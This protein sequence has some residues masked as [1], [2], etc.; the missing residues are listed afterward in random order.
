MKKTKAAILAA[1]LCASMTGCSNNNVNVTAETT[2]DTTDSETAS[3]TETTTAE[4]TTESETTTAEETATVTETTVE[5]AE[6]TEDGKLI[7]PSG[8][9]LDK[10][11]IVSDF[12][13][14]SLSEI[15]KPVLIAELSDGSNIYGVC[16]DGL[17][18][19]N[20]EKLFVQYTIIEHDGIADEFERNCFGRFGSGSPVECELINID[21]DD[22]MEIFTRTY[23]AGG[24]MCCIYD[25]AVF[26]MNENGHYE[27]IT[28]DIPYVDYDPM[29]CGFGPKEKAFADEML[30]KINA[31]WADDNGSVRFFTD[32]SECTAVLDK[33]LFGDYTNEDIKE[34][35]NYISS[36]KEFSF[37]GDT[38]YLKITLMVNNPDCTCTAKGELIYS[39]GSF[40]LGNVLLDNEW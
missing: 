22:D 8:W 16:V 6:T 9:V 19:E 21:D 24:T 40:T 23:I 26:D 34:N 38:L 10:E 20:G 25:M 31:E 18:D 3:T 4:T 28:I 29:E 2:Y 39:D 5:A 27:M 17:V 32:T 15:D 37:E 36:L 35:M 12:E 30:S 33:E 11:V 7:S 1:L 14:Y 13:D